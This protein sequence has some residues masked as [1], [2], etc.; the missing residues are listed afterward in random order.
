MSIKKYVALFVAVM[1]ACAAF[2]EKNSYASHLAKAKE[3][4]TK[5]QWIFALGEYYEA[6]LAEP[7]LAAEEAYNGW[8][9]LANDIK[10]GKPGHGEYG[11]F[12]QYD[13]WIA[14]MREYERYWTEYCPR[15][16]VFNKPVRTEINSANRTATYTVGV[17]WRWSEK[18]SAMYDVITKG[19][20]KAYS[21][22]WNAEYL[23]GWPKT[24]VYNAP[25]DKGKFLQNGAVQTQNRTINEINSYTDHHVYRWEPL[26]TEPAFSAG[27]EYGG[28]GEESTTMY[29]IKF[30]IVDS[31]KK[32]IFQSPRFML[33]YH[34]N[35]Y[36]YYYN[37]PVFLHT[38]TVSAEQMT[39]IDAG[40]ITFVPEGVYLKYGDHPI[41]V[42]IRPNS[43]DWV[44]NLPEIQ[45]ALDKVT[46][47]VGAETNRDMRLDANKFVVNVLGRLMSSKAKAEEALNAAYQQYDG[48]IGR[49]A[50]AT[51][52]TLIFH[53]P[54]Y[55]NPL[56]SLE[57]E[58]YFVAEMRKKLIAEYGE[59][60]YERVKA[61][62]FFNALSRAASLS[63]AYS[64]GGKTKNSYFEEIE[65]LIANY[66]NIS[67]DTN[68]SGYRFATN[69]EFET[70]P[71]SLRIS[72]YSNVKDQIIVRKKK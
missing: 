31:D 56:N 4:E 53:S 61:F 65:F 50:I 29:D 71:L 69:K 44:K 30:R 8:T 6:M 48:V 67:C 19:Y 17:S 36:N 37:E 9:V 18:Y 55:G 43:R 52:K 5:K 27:F 16:I 57:G 23:K 66:D 54:F 12:E 49:M 15:V 62:Q 40:N 64:V 32:V 10:S 26:Y 1:M 70:L 58:Y 25:A 63:P 39:L 7:T 34:Y 24:S 60:K 21:S 20:E 28:Y 59:E 72:S 14:L 46:F 38:F 22:E 68:A 41:N 13:G 2:A 42:D 3:Y 45:I 35:Y 47:E 33:D 51:T 11:V